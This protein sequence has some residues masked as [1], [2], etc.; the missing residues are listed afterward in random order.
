MHS[1]DREG[2]PMVVAIDEHDLRAALPSPAASPSAFDVRLGRGKTP[3]ANAVLSFARQAG[4]KLDEVGHR[5]YPLVP[6][7][8]GTAVAARQAVR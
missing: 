1:I 4:L 8:I 5:P 2:L 7:I 6:M 3:K